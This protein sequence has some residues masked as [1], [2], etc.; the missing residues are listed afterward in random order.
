MDPRILYLS[1]VAQN[2]EGYATAIWH[3]YKQHHKRDSGH[4]M[5]SSL[6]VRPVF[7]SRETVGILLSHKEIGFGFPLSIRGHVIIRD[8]LSGFRPTVDCLPDRGRLIVCLRRE[9]P[10]ARLSLPQV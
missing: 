1:T 2:K 9:L 10:P 4:C 7:P 3:S 5:V 6:C 8:A